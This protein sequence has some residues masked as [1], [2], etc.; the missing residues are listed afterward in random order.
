M[1]DDT[2][3]ATADRVLDL[4]AELE[5][6]GDATTTG[7]ELAFAKAELHK[8]IDGV[9]GVVSSPGVGRVVLIHGNGR[10]SKIA[11]PDLPYL[12]TKPATFDQ[13]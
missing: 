8:W 6:A 3:Q 4:E 1:S 2:I 9:V 11:S 13:P 7:D 5:S 10:T 12:V